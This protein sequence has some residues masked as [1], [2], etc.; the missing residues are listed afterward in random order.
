MKT[1]QP[2]Q[3]LKETDLVQEIDSILEKVKH[4]E[5]HTIESAS[6]NIKALILSRQIPEDI[7]AEI[8]KI[9]EGV[10]TKLGI[11]DRSKLGQLIGSVMKE[12]KG[13]ADGAVVKLVVEQLF[14]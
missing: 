11:S 6:A 1:A 12:M 14:T 8:K 2:D 9:A 10:K 3:F 4:D 5:I 7:E 13:R